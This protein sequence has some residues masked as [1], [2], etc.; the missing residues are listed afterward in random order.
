MIVGKGIYF[1]QVQMGVEAELFQLHTP[2]IS[3][4][5]LG[6]NL[7][8]QTQKQTCTSFKREPLC[9]PAC[10][11]PMNTNACSNKEEKKILSGT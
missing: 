5:L 9:C 4:K 11:G 6:K 1:A 7:R 8:I 3:D 10:S 2:E